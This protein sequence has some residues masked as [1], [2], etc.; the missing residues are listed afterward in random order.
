[1]LGWFRRFCLPPPPL[2]C[3]FLPVGLR[4]SFLLPFQGLPVPGQVCWCWCSLLPLFFCVPLLVSLLSNSHF[5]FHLCL[6]HCG[7]VCVCVTRLNRRKTSTFFVSACRGT[8]PVTSNLVQRSWD[9]T[10]EASKDAL[11]C[12]CIN[13]P[14]PKPEGQ[15]PSPCPAPGR[16]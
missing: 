15:D 14:G 8:R 11:M 5:H 1:M 3:W 16:I 4:F 12:T 6:P 9:V 13:G 2:V 7:G 10:G